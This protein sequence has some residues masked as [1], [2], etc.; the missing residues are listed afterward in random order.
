MNGDEKTARSLSPLIVVICHNLVSVLK[1]AVNLG[2]M[3]VVKSLSL[4]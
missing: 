3:R 2:F 4:H 1:E